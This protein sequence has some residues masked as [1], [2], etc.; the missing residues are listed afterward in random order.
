M[1]FFVRLENFYKFRLPACYRCRGCGHFTRPMRELLI[2]RFKD[3]LTEHQPAMIVLHGIDCWRDW[4]KRY[5]DAS[6]TERDR[7]IAD[8]DRFSFATSAQ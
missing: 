7:L 5:W 3:K 8:S 2:M 4:E 6:E 1:S